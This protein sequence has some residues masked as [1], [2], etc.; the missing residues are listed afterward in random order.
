MGATK[1]C[2]L[3]CY[4]YDGILIWERVLQQSGF[5]YPTVIKPVIADIDNDSFKEIIVPY[6]SVYGEDIEYSLNIF[7]Y[8]G[9]DYGNGWPLEGFTALS[10]VSIGNID[11]D[12]D[13]EILVIQNTNQIAI[14]HNDTEMADGWPY[15]LSD[16]W[17]ML[18]TTPSIIDLDFDNQCEIIVVLSNSSDQSYIAIFDNQGNILS[19]WPKLLNKMVVWNSQGV[20]DFNPQNNSLEFIFAD[21][22][23]NTTVHM[24]DINGNYA[25]GWPVT[26]QNVDGYYSDFV[27][28]SLGYFDENEYTL[29]NKG[30]GSSPLVI[31]DLQS[32]G[33]LQIIVTGMNQLNILNQDGTLHTPFPGLKIPN[34]QI[35]SPSIADLNNDNNLDL[36]FVQLEIDEAS[37]HAWQKL[38]AYDNTGNILPD[39]PVAIKKYDDVLNFNVLSYRYFT[40]TI[41]DLDMDGDIEIAVTGFRQ[42]GNNPYD[43][44]MIAIFDLGS[45]YNF[46]NVE[47]GD[48]LKNNWNNGVYCNYIENTL[49]GYTILYDNIRLSDIVEV[50]SGDVIKFY[51]NQK[52]LPM[53]II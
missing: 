41:D 35:F 33:T 26:I 51:Q 53:I 27:Y 1:P 20:A 11:N 36:S 9:S 23:Y 28:T 49:Y 43:N 18:W 31:G 13:L 15:Q 39:F 2:K 44:G 24:F 30:N 4:N 22:G 12:D 7:K 8:D 52:L 6:L 29:D 10:N 21:D 5:Q 38:Y 46:E 48:V 37:N 17:N 25:P 40:P 50:P 42:F 16:N 14:Y 45:I 3:V 34:G 47:W 32:D 19:G